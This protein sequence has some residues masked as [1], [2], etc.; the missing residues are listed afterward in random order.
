M[1]RTLDTDTLDGFARHLAASWLR[2]DRKGVKD[3]WVD[4]PSYVM[5][6][7]YNLTYKDVFEY[8]LDKMRGYM[9]PAALAEFDARAAEVLTPRDDAVLEQLLREKLAID[10]DGNH[11]PGAVG[12][13][14]VGQRTVGKRIVGKREV[15]ETVPVY[16]GEA[17]E[18]AAGRLTDSQP[19]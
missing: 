9:G 10:R 5:Q 17:E 11:I 12:T 3:K 19:H 16:A 18:R 13:T 15:A 8:V 4:G 14:V 7:L 1:A 2:P 6:D